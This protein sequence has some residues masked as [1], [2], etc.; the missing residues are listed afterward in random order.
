MTRSYLYV[1]DLMGS[2]AQL[3]PISLTPT[4]TLPTTYLG[5]PSHYQAGQRNNDRKTHCTPEEPLDEEGGEW[6]A[7]NVS[8]LERDMLLAFEEPEELSSATA[9][10]PPQSPHLYTEQ[11]HPQ[12]DQEH[13]QREAFHRR[14]E[15]L[16]YCSPFRSQDQDKEELEEQ[17]Q[18]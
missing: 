1:L 11:P 6:S 5:H 4:A 18:Q 14:I 10:T 12:I 15:E 9:P 16:G 3:F 17:Q 7:E 13:E 8:D 2:K